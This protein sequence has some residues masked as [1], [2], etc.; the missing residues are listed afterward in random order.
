MKIKDLFLTQEEFDLRETEISG[1]LKTYPIPENLGKY[2]ESKNYISHHQDSGSLKEKI[3]KFL[4][5]FNLNY[6]KKIV[7]KLQANSTRYL[8]II[9]FFIRTP[10]EPIGISKEINFLRFT[11]SLKNCITV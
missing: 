6:K 7:K 5:G 1:I 2:Y 9:L 4:Q 3:Y 11:Q 8:P 10:E